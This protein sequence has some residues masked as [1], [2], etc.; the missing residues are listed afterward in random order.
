[1]PSIRLLIEKGADVN[2]TTLSGNSAMLMAAQ[3]GYPSLL[4]AFISLGLIKKEN[5][6]DRAIAF[7][8]E[9]FR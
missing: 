4:I 9:G 6:G 8:Y 1:M 5:R 3:N 7:Y 2:A